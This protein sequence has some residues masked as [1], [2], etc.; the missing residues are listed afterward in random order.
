MNPISLL[1]LFPFAY[2]SS[3]AVPITESH[4]VSVENASPAGREIVEID[5]RIWRVHQAQNGD[6]WFGSN[7]NGLYKYDG[8]R[9][10]HYTEAD[11]LV[12]L[13][14]RDIKEDKRGNLFVSTTAAVN[15]FDGRKWTELKIELPLNSDGWELNP[16][17]VWIVA[18]HT[19]GGLCRYDGEKLISLELSTS[20]WINV[21]LAKN[22]DANFSVDGLY[23]IYKDRRGHIWFGTGDVGLCRYDGKSLSWMYEERLTTT[24]RGGSFG[25]RSIYEDRA[26]GFW[27]CNTRQRFEVSSEVRLEEGYSRLDYK[28]QVGLPE[29][30]SD[31]DD[32][33]AYYMAITEDD[34][35]SLWMACGNNEVW[36][37]D[38]DQITRFPLVDGAY[39]ISILCDREGKLW[40]GTLDHGIFTFAGKS[41]EPFKPQGGL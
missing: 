4:V 11:G 36:K 7:G 39:A 6:H 1:L 27:I 20:P 12:G 37:F 5:S 38:G 34:S 13:Q 16:D 24:P 14:V 9:V 40:V 35:G 18:H 19:H 17:D 15:K 22:P 30:Q 26:G 8:K 21:K 29:A 2:A 23:T 3:K 25:I 31:A 33:F 28:K 10:T 41:F 32:N